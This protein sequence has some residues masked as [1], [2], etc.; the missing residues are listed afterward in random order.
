[1]MGGAKGG[2]PYKMTKKSPNAQLGWSMAATSGHN[3]TKDLPRGKQSE[4]G[5]GE[6]KKSPNLG[7][8]EGGSDPSSLPPFGP[9]L[10]L[11]LRLPLFSARPSGLSWGRT[12][13]FEN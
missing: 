5:A 9:P 4:N 12:V 11:G 1:M 7:F 2:S 8:G 3:S 13:G 10:C 6:R